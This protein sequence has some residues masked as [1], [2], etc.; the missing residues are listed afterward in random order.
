VIIFSKPPTSFFGIDED[1]FDTSR[2]CTYAL[3]SNNLP[4]DFGQEGKWYKD[5]C[6][7][8]NSFVCKMHHS[9]YTRDCDDG[10]KLVDTTNGQSCIKEWIQLFAPMLVATK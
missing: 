10:W 4:G 2:R 1:Q 8:E 7:R 6:N 9:R 5:K 3:F